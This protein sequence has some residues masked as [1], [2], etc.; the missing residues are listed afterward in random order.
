MPRN[1]PP[2]PTKPRPQSQRDTQLRQWKRAEHA[3]VV[4]DVLR[5]LRSV[6]LVPRERGP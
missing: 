4:A 3:A 6:V 2:R 5:W 1:A